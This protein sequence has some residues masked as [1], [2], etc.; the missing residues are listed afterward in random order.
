MT[1]QPC[2]ALAMAILALSYNSQGGP[3]LDRAF[4][5]VSVCVKKVDGPG[6]VSFNLQVYM[7]QVYSVAF[8][9]FSLCV[10]LLRFSSVLTVSS[11][12]RGGVGPWSW[13]AFVPCISYSYATPQG[14]VGGGTLCFS[15]YKTSLARQA[16]LRYCICPKR[17][18][19]G[20]EYFLPLLPLFFFSFFPLG[21]VGIDRPLLFCPRIYDV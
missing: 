17:R 3:A 10:F 5:A 15:G 18:G 19:R 11:V 9:P 13:S 7:D 14:V 21:G 1:W 12:Q 8:V 4:S 20:C 6:T 16:S 2:L